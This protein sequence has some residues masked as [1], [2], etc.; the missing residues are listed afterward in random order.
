MA[1]VTS[2]AL[3]DDLNGKKAEESVQ[4]GLD[5]VSY[6]IDLGKSNATALRKG[7][8]EFVAVARQIKPAGLFTAARAERK[9]SRSAPVDRER[10]EYLAAVREWSAGQGTPLASRGR[11]S[12]DILTAYEASLAS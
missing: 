2:V 4:F 10:K 1:S 8:A 7:L 9:R 6:E 5:G 3:V 12:A 11:I